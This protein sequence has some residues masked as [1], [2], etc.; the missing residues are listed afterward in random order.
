VAGCRNSRQ[1]AIAARQ[2]HESQLAE[3]QKALG[4][5]RRELEE[6]GEAGLLVTERLLKYKVENY[7]FSDFHNDL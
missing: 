3:V 2:Q 1:L 6:I 4:Q 7:T 5:G